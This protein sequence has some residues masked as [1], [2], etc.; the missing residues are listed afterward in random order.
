[1]HRFAHRFVLRVTLVTVLVVTT[2]VAHARP[3]SVYGNGQL[4]LVRSSGTDVIAT[5]GMDRSERVVDDSGGRSLLEGRFFSA[6]SWSPDG[7]KLAYGFDHNAIGPTVIRSELRIAD[8]RR[9]VPRAV[10][11]VPFAG[12]VYD[13]AWSPD[14]RRLAF[15][16]LTVNTP[17]AA[18]TWTLIGSRSDVWIIGA[19]GNGLRRIS[20]VNTSFDTR[21]T[22][23]RDGRTLAFLSD[24][25]GG[26]G[27]YVVDV[28]AIPALPKRLT[29]LDKNVYFA[30]WAPDGR[31]L[32]Y[33]ASPLLN[34]LQY[35]GTVSVIGRDGRAAR[36]YPIS[37]ADDVSWSPDGRQLAV[38][39]L[40]NGQLDGLAAVDVRS[41]RVRQLTSGQAL[42]PAWSPDGRVIAVLRYVQG[43]S[44]NF[45]EIVP[46]DGRHPSRAL[47][48]PDRYSW[49]QGPTWRP[50]R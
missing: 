40:V 33:V 13:V 29:P 16:L 18:A 19:D 47:T 27:L 21:P 45:V 14:G 26:T 9:G 34:L 5:L 41:G 32:A 8:V 23:A 11:T 50:A 2:G 30:R 24:Q 48:Y 43:E 15:T 31:R 22:W 12:V 36:S 20:T 7:T 44:G 28:D 3:G 10:L 49:L 17:A 37:S 6:P 25:A 35:D 46:A 39:R 1:M 4:A 38:A 42:S